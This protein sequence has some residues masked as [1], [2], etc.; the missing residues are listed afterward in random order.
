MT[1]LRTF[2]QS[3]EQKNCSVCRAAFTC[4]P[5]PGESSCWCDQLPHVPLV[6]TQDQDCLCPK[7]LAA[8][9]SNSAP[10]GLEGENAGRGI[11]PTETLQPSLIEGED[12]YW[13]GPAM[14]F[15]AHYHRRRGYCC[16]SGCRHCPYRKT[17]TNESK[18]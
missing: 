6:G 11:T 3:G 5:K 18:F 9:I 10:P 16:D 15:T 14:V 1:L 4:G 8:A 7:C 2:P 17:E 13:E 12:Y